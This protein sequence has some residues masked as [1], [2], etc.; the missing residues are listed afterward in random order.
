MY[1]AIIMA[2]YL[3]FKNAITHTNLCYRY[4]CP[5]ATKVTKC[6]VAFIAGFSTLDSPYDK[7]NNVAC[8]TSLD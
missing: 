6:K 4:L 7:A 1:P 2:V 5:H 3:C 8:D